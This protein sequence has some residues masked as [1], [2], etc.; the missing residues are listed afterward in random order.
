MFLSLCRDTT[1]SHLC[2]FAVSHRNA[3]RCCCTGIVQAQEQRFVLRGD[4]SELNHIKEDLDALRSPPAKTTRPQRSSGDNNTS[5]EGQGAT[6]RNHH[7]PLPA[8]V[9]PA[10]FIGGPRTSERGRVEALADSDESHSRDGSAEAREDDDDDDDFT[11]TDDEDDDGWHGG[12]G[13]RSVGEFDTA[14]TADISGASSMTDTS[15]ELQRLLRERRVLAQNPSYGASHPLVR[16]IDA[17]IALQQQQQ[18]PV[19]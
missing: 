9:H 1:Q 8:E 5:P 13:N 15:V 11:L 16:R 14:T 7:L 18:V 6:R 4:R 19:N 17:A 12:Q 3:Y 10:D 2:P